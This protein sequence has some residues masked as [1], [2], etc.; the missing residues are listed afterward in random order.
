MWAF[1]KDDV[2][3]IVEIVV[4]IEI[5]EMVMMIEMVVMIEMVAI[6]EMIEIVEM[7]ERLRSWSCIPTAFHLYLF[8]ISSI[9]IVEVDFRNMPR[10]ID[11]RTWINAS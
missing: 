1:A 5:V 4:M 6:I 9:R 7:I 11:E 2:I 8:F 10:G 3:E